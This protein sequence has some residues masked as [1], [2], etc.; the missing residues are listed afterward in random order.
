MVTLSF[1]VSFFVICCLLLRNFQSDRYTL[2]NWAG[3]VL[4][5]TSTLLA[6][7]LSVSLCTQFDLPPCLVANML[8]FC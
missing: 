1:L 7:S 8:R 3:A 4:G 2:M 5:M 6:A